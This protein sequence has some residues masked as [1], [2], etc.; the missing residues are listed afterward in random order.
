MTETGKTVTVTHSYIRRKVEYDLDDLDGVGF[1]FSPPCH[2]WVKPLGKDHIKLVE[3]KEELIAKLN[4]AL[5]PPGPGEVTVEWEAAL[6]R[7]DTDDPDSAPHNLRL[8]GDGVVS[9]NQSCGLAITCRQNRTIDTF[10]EIVNDACPPPKK[11]TPAPRDEL[12]ES[13]DRLLVQLKC[14]VVSYSEDVVDDIA[15]AEK[16]K[17][18][19]E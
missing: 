2:V 5:N 18:S 12:Q 17:E 13:H 19:P 4:A 7:L 14:R 8:D 15:R 1:G 6:G 3:T 9:V 10:T 11:P 16:L